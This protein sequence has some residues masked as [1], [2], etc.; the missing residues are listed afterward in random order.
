MACSS[1]NITSA[2]DFS[3]QRAAL[4]QLRREVEAL[5]G[6][7]GS[8]A[9]EDE[10]SS[11]G[12][13]DSLW[14]AAPQAEPTQVLRSGSHTMSA[15][16]ASTSKA[17]APSRAENRLQANMGELETKA[18]SLG[19]ELKEAEEE[20][21]KC[22]AVRSVAKAEWSR[23]LALASSAENR[24]EKR[25]VSAQKVLEEVNL[26]EAQHE[27]VYRLDRDRLRQRLRNLRMQARQAEKQLAEFRQDERFNTEFAQ[28]GGEFDSDDGDC[29]KST[30]SAGSLAT[31]QPKKSRAFANI[32]GNQASRSSSHTGIKRSGIHLVDYKKQLEE[33][34]ENVFQLRGRRCELQEAQKELEDREHELRK[35]A[36]LSEKE[37]IRFR[38]RSDLELEEGRL[39]EEATEMRAELQTAEN[40]GESA[41]KEAARLRY[42]H[43]RALGEL[44]DRDMQFQEHEQ[45]EA[46]ALRKIDDFLSN[47]PPIANE[48]R[49][50]H[51]AEWLE[52]DISA[53]QVGHMKRRLSEMVADASARAQVLE[54]AVAELH[55]DLDRR[56]AI[57]LELVERQS[58]TVGA[59]PTSESPT[60]TSTG[61][62]QDGGARGSVSTPSS[63]LTASPV[64]QQG[65]DGHML[66]WQALEGEL[67]H[68]RGGWSRTAPSR[69]SCS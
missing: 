59:C 41:R 33:S 45:Q 51:V 15:A 66:E 7:D 39:Q 1:A 54:Q 69:T 4:E 3:K 31:F 50:A 26:R 17:S 27:A 42:A 62:E 53:R 60:N 19:S 61:G 68:Q 12:T 5:D 64:G 37:L 65:G 48:E 56:A 14:S 28:L 58:A 36:R 29:G 55:C 10:Q 21:A 20:V 30:C 63:S 6:L 32:T 38:K 44:S 22:S 2:F 49:Q 52:A 18:G 16:S 13:P 8:E 47:G 40:E 24:E 46:N 57:I 34:E 67:Q 43:D 35:A 25:M 23:A 9:V 11:L